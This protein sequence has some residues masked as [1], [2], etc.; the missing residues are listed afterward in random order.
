MKAAQW[1]RSSNTKGNYR[2]HSKQNENQRTRQ[3]PRQP[4]GG[5]DGLISVNVWEN[6]TDK[7]AFDSFTHERRYEDESG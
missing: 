3:N 5:Q 1:C 4:A 6:I 7:G 2:Y